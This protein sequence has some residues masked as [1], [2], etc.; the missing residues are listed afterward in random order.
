MASIFQI[1]DYSFCIHIEA[2]DSLLQ[3]EFPV[4]LERVLHG[5][6]QSQTDTIHFDSAFTTTS[7]TLPYQ[8]E[9]I[10]DGS[11][12]HARV[13]LLSGEL[14]AMNYVDYI[15]PEIVN[16]AVRRSVGY[17]WVHGACLYKEGEL[18]LLLGKTGT[19]KT[20]LSLGLLSRGYQL[21]TDDIILI[22]PHGGLIVPVPRCPKVRYP[23][24]DYLRDAGFDLSER[25]QLVDRY[26]ILPHDHL[27]LTPTDAP[28][29][30]VFLLQRSPELLTKHGQL[31]KVSGLLGMLPQ[32]NLVMLDPDFSQSTRIFRHARFLNMNL[33]NYHTDLDT[34]ANNLL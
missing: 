33:S 1:A 21:L 2:Q 34:I 4:L 15:E 25:A 32:S 12:I 16:E 8:L 3:D 24:H 20:T 19:G 14:S 18:T 22:N 17:L 9:F 29:T 30:R 26:V 6:Y 23:A 13:K 10:D 5:F 7:S 28:I 31:D 27:F 11:V